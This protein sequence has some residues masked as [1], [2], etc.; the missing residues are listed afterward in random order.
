MY[1]GLDLG[2]SNS[3][4][5]GYW[6]GELRLF[7]TS[8][9]SDVL[10]SVVYIDKRGH[11]FFG[12]RAYDQVFL[13][14]ENTAQ[15]FKRL[16]GTNST[17]DFAASGIKLSPVECSAEILR[18]L[19]RQ[20]VVESGRDEVLGT[21]I[22]TPAAF[23][24]MQSQA[25]RA[26]AEAAGLERVALLQ[27]PI[28]AAMAAMQTA[29]RKSGVFL[30]FDLGGGTFDL[31]MVRSTAGNVAIVG[32]AGVNMLGGRDF[33][34]A[35]LSE[36]VRPWL[37]DNFDL[38]GS[39]ETEPQRR[40]ILRIAQIAVEKAKI[41]L[42]SEPSATIH[43]SEEEIRCK[44]DSGA[45]IFLDIPLT[46]DELD[47]LVRP[48][49]MRTIE[50][51]QRL[52]HD[53]D[54]R[55]EDIDRIVF[56]GGPTK[57]PLLR[58]FVPNALGIP[59]DL[60][61]D[62]MTAVALGAAVFAESREWAADGS[63]RKSSRGVRETA[64][65][66]AL[67]LEYKT[68]SAQ[69]SERLRIRGGKPGYQVQVD[70]ED[71]WTSG[72]KALDTE[73]TLELPLGR[74]GLVSHFRLFLFDPEGRPDPNGVATFEIQRTAGSVLGVP[75][76]LTLAVKVRENVRSARNTLEP[77]LKKGT[78]LPAS[79]STP[80]RAA[81]E[82]KAGGD[83][84]L[85]FEIYQ[86]TEESVYDP[87]LQLHVG[88]FEIQASSL[89]DSTG[90]RPGDEIRFNWSMNESGLMEAELEIPSIKQTLTGKFFVPEAGHRV[91]DGQEGRKL[92]ESWIERAEGDLSNA[93]EVVG[94]A[95]EIE[96]LESAL[97]A[98]KGR[99]EAADDAEANRRAAEEA[100]HVRQQV[101]RLLSDPKNRARAAESDL[102]AIESEY[103]K[104]DAEAK[105]EASD[106]RFLELAQS[107]RAE[108]SRG[109]QASWPH[110][111]A[112]L[113]E[114]R[115]LDAEA[116]WR[117]PAFIVGAF[118]YAASSAHLASDRIA[119]GRLTQEGLVALKAGNLQALMIV[120]AKMLG[121]MANVG[122]SRIDTA[123]LA[124]IVRA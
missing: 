13:S 120:T 55:A 82:V 4:V 78:P 39:F 62:P 108:I 71:G 17:I 113:D 9:G 63:T 41:A 40:R 105:D 60:S 16:M 45:D 85:S 10:P 18:E 28:A 21:V 111:E 47:N 43:A 73:T 88:N 24:Q 79:G 77:I 109:S 115:T 70:R 92:A 68:R 35:I 38:P 64:G 90:I 2:T 50:V 107:A 74:A 42:S 1:I 11:R 69:E 96:K 23:N 12:R 117:S 26:A 25:T 66:V 80:F 94:D 19:R 48:E 114:L 67:Q 52:L 83:D 7:K 44:D 84:A 121:D 49:V 46:R 5:A 112:I 33:D 76:A 75:A 51:S 56:I 59:A 110:F 97:A 29:K 61:V 81:H 58:E 95:G 116:N 37:H 72:R 22:T 34:R 30:V 103:S 27:E 36:F 86:V 6:D 123:R 100:R 3:A 14:P 91:Y 65:S 98:E 118:K 57:M 15:G 122:D 124:S 101:H 31:A 106:R 99:F 102:R 87:D 53:A 8:D 119:H 104:V 93:R 32:H 20:A 54:L 89:P